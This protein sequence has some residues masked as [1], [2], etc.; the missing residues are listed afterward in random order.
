MDVNQ[1]ELYVRC[2]KVYRNGEEVTSGVDYSR[3]GY[4]V[5]QTKSG[6]EVTLKSNETLAVVFMSGAM[7]N[8][9]VEREASDTRSIGLYW[10]QQGNEVA[11]MVRRV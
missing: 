1:D 7:M 6:R 4:P 2:A 9:K 10:S 8:V 5:V 3:T 11:V